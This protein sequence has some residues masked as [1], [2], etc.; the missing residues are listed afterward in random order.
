MMELKELKEFAFECMDKVAAKNLAHFSLSG[1]DFSITI[2]THAPAAPVAAAP[3]APAQ[4]AVSATATAVAEEPEEYTGT[5]VPAP[6]VGTFYAANSPEEPPIVEIG[7]KVAKGDPLC[8]IEAMK[9]MNSIVSPCDGTVS[10]ILV[11]NG[12]LVEYKQPLFVIE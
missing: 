6:L 1:E 7:S 5:V 11:Q 12:D 2:E 9:T 8:I 10:R 4:V 3:A